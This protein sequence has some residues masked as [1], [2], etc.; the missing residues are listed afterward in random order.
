MKTA[1]PCPP[2]IIGAGLA[3]L[4]VALALA[5]RP[6]ILIAR[7]TT[8]EGTS[9]ILAQGGIAVAAG[10]DDRPERHADDTI[11]AGAGLCD[12]AVVRAI[13]ADGPGAL[14]QLLAWGVPFDR[15]ANGHLTFSLEGAHSRRRVAHVG[16]DATGAGITRTLARAVAHVPS[17]TVIE[18]ADIVRLILHEG[19]V[20]GVLMRDRHGVR[21]L[22]TRQV[23]LATGGAG[24][25]W[26]HTTSPR[27]SWGQGLALAARAGA[28]MRDLEF[29]QFHPT[30]ID[31][32]DDPMPLASEALRG[33]GARLVNA[34]GHTLL[35]S[36]LAPR[37]VVARAIFDETKRSG[38]VLLDARMIPAFA[39][40]FPTID[41][42]C[43]AAQIDPTRQPIPVRPVAHYT[44]GGVATDLQGRTSVPGLWACGECAATGLHGANRLASNSLLEAVVMGL[45]VAGDLPE[46]SPSFDDLALD[47]AALPPVPLP[48]VEGE[49]HALRLLM[50]EDFGIVREAA[51]MRVGRDRLRALARR[52]D[53][54]LVGLM[55]AE[56]ALAREES[57]GAHRR[58]DFPEPV[59]ALAQSRFTRLDLDTLEQHDVGRGALG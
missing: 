22:S 41:A 31:V 34:E 50:E 52:S 28:V 40:H 26:A 33:E 19:R 44:M 43:Q 56:A 59:E 9:S 58:S 38:R 13:T 29:M 23:V 54:A 37:D 18:D 14:D 25:L 27:G 51:S 47:D 6:V 4:T 53:R 45:R 55:I 42:F 5:P 8:G 11:K 32:G 12:P 49:Q 48:E 57:R 1:T 30:A 21:R 39:S 36:D 3:G 24:S 35:P 15:D 7:A 46:V 20:A 16:G 17:I 10:P 2:V